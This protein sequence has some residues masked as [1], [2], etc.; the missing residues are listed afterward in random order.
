MRRPWRILAVALTACALL[1]LS[2]N[3]VHAEA[4]YAYE[5]ITPETFDYVRYANDN[6]DLLSAYGYDKS[7]L[8]QHYQT[9]GKAEGRLAHTLPYKPGRIA[10]FDYLGDESYYFDAKRYADDNP[11][12]K[13]VFGY[14]KAALWNH[15]KTRGIQEGR[16]AYGTSYNVDAKLKVFDTAA[17][18]TNDSMSER[19]K[20]KA[21]H[22]WII[23]HTQY[24]KAN[25]DKGTIPDDSYSI[26]GVMLNGKA[27]CSGYATTFDYFMYVLGIEHEQVSG[28]AT[29]SKGITGDHSWNRVLLGNQWYYVD[30]TWDDPVSSDGKDVL[31]Y[32]Y[33]LISDEQI[34]KDHVA[35]EIYKTY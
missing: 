4:N 34:S 7:K 21:V 20:I 11:D 2:A 19:D 28:E 30:C 6:P 26:A 22:D 24:D 23:N 18:I 1:H 17:S 12:L 33:F 3:C 15:Y 32:T 35:K 5:R 25:Y 27:V 31:R 9:A 16:T 10:V 8:Y 14:D 13:A 29:N